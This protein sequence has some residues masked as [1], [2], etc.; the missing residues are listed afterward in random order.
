MDFPGDLVQT[1]LRRQWVLQNCSNF[2]RD[3]VNGVGGMPTSDG[4]EHGRYPGL[5]STLPVGVNS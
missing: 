2:D 1:S 4:L 5:D 3:D